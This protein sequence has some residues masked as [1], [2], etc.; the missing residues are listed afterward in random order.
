LKKKDEEIYRLRSHN[1][2][3][4]DEAKRVKEKKKN[5]EN[6]EEMVILDE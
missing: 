2:K 1:K 4:L 5:Y 6:Q 3:P